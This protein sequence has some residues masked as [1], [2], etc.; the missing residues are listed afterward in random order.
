[1]VAGWLLL[2]SPVSQGQQVAPTPSA[3]AIRILAPKPGE[4]ITNSFVEVK[5]ELVASATAS[6]SPTF[7]IRLDDRDPVHTTDQQ[8]TFTG[9]QPGKHTISIEVLD[10]NNT[11]VAGTRSEVQFTLVNPGRGE[12]QPNP[13]TLTASG[14]AVRLRLA[15]FSQPAS[16]SS[17]PKK[18]DQSPQQQ[19]PR[20][21]SALPLLSV[22]GVGVLIGGIISARRTRPRRSASERQQ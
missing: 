20:S 12:A 17:N 13:G 5:Y 14:P 9:L 18:P 11:P 15:A 8:Q 3:A 19:L 22:I 1:M 6:S 21:G 4:R 7:Q 16:D 10:A 2:F